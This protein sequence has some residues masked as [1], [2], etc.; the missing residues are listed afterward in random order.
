MI[1][2]ILFILSL[3]LLQC[4]TQNEDLEIEVIEAMRGGGSDFIWTQARAAA[5]PDGEGSYWGLMTMS[6]KL[7]SGDDVYY[8]LY[9]SI[10]VDGGETWS[11]PEVIPGLRIHEIDGGS[12]RSMS[13]M[14]PQW[15]DNSGKVLNIGKSFFYTDDH[16]PDRSRREVAYATFDPATN[17]WGPYRSLELPE[18][19]KDGKLLTAP[20]SGCVQ[21]S[22]NE[23]GEVLLPVAYRALTKEQYESSSR[24]T[25]E[26]RNN[27]NNDDIGGS[28]TVVRCS[29]DGRTLT[30]LEIGNSLT[31]KQGRGFSEP[32]IVSFKGKWFLTIRSDKTAHV[33]A[34]DDGL[35]FGALKEW[36]FDDGSKLG[37]YNTQQHWAVV[38]NRL[39]L[40]YTRPN[41]SNDHVFRHRAPLY[42]ARVDPEAVAVLKSTE[43]VCLPEDGV[44]LG[45]FGITQ[46]SKNEVWVVSSEYHRDDSPDNKN[47]VWVARIKNE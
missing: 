5:L 44:A 43:R 35:H 1:R 29:F 47:R 22:L 7:K 34:S 45:N 33:A 25:F 19:D 30:F 11:E 24:E 41:G 17:K 12:R 28:V 16:G 10:T 14:T 40:V 36:T 20:G 31:I 9:Q 23:N 46:V 13:D 27:M 3:L 42:I 8:D 18:K 37:S 2:C 32:S 4:S 38:N 6:Q 15:H 21:Y 39:Y 26:V